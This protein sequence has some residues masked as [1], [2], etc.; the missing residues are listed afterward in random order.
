MV[1]LGSVSV[2]GVLFLIAIAVAA[3]TTPVP[4]SEKGKHQ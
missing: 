3:W 1:R 2:I 4:G